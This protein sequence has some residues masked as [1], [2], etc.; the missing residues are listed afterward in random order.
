V[1]TITHAFSVSV[2]HD[3]DMTRVAMDLE[4]GRQAV[5][6]RAWRDAHDGLA[7]AD[8]DDPLPASDLEL[9]ATAAYMLGDDEEYVRTLERAHGLY[10]EAD[11]AGCAAR[12]AFWLGIDRMLH[13]QSA[14]AN[15]WF[16][17]AERLLNRPGDYVER[18]YLLI[19]RMLE[20]V[21]RGDNEAA[22]DCAAEVVAI[23]ERYGDDDLIALTAQE[24]AHAL[25][26]LGRTDEGLRLLDETMLLATSDRLTP[27]VTGLI[28]CNTIAFCQGAYELRRAREWTDALTSWCEKQPDMVRHT[29]LCLVH[30]A[31]ILELSGAWAD[32]LE[33]AGRAYERLTRGTTS[34]SDAGY[35]RYRQGEV[36][37]LR[38]DFSAAEDAY[39]EAAEL[40]FEP[41]P[42]LALLRLGQ[43][44][45]EAAAGAIRR[46]LGETSEP[47]ARLRLL[48]GYVDIMLA[49]ND[50]DAARD[51]SRELAAIAERQAIVAVEAA[52]SKARGSVQLA[53]GDPQSAL[54][55]LRDSFRLW[56]ELG[57]P[58]EAARVRA[59]LGQA[60]G[61]LGD[62]DGAML[63][64]EAARRTFTELGSV[65]ELA[66]LDALSGEPPAETHGLTER[67]LEV[68]RLVAA[69]E[70]NRAIAA[71]LVISEHTVARHVQNIFA[72]LGVS[73]RTAAT[74]FAFE[75]GLT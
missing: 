21:M 75:H 51:G 64:F 14:P 65:T 5:R 28:Y 23:G 61:A 8:R 10:V 54:G 32:A 22:H 41:Q 70:S 72:K 9:L 2:T 36:H 16:A 45:A 63:E 26:R 15:G 18:G 31:E 29:G 50:L 40:G 4:H 67:E 7:A 74:A 52:S 44:R 42:G 20:Q 6:R 66:R 49:G 37:R 73:S 33:E 43:G 17:R 55:A 25:M 12:T 59:L 60:C 56:Q 46:A 47:F 48:P 58:H 30:R 53:D 34:R 13:G 39:T 19:P 57:V 68:L 69:G 38:G 27:I 35:A 71:K 3:G 24:Q 11:D 1:T 62:A